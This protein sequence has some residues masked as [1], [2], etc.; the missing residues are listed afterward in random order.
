MNKLKKIC[1]SLVGFF[2]GVIS[3]VSAI[4]LDPSRIEL[5]YGVFEPEE[6]TIGEKILSIG[7]VALPAI[8]FIVGVFVILS[9]KLTKKVK[10]II[11]CVL[12]TLAIFA[13]ILMR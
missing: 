6:P 1:I 4:S 2:I 8:L 7:K 9:R 3:K 11:V 10:A 5:K 12:I 13:Y